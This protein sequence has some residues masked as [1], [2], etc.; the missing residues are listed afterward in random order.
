MA[1]KVPKHIQIK[2]SLYAIRYH[3]ER[4]SIDRQHQL[5]FRETNSRLIYHNLIYSIHDHLYQMGEEWNSSQATLI[6]RRPVKCQDNFR[7]PRYHLCQKFD[8]KSIPRK[9]TRADFQLFGTTIL[10]IHRI[11]S[12]WR[13]YIRPHV[14]NVTRLFINQ[15][16]LHTVLNF[17]MFVSTDDIWVN[18]IIRC[19]LHN[20]L[21]AET[22]VCV[23]C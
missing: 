2:I 19:C 3:N 11:W 9:C 23:W 20:E 13:N 6:N 8:V 7:L 12:D 14:L 18:E 16:N 22:G 4:N 5:V 15:Y 1:S 17:G 10:T 21:Q